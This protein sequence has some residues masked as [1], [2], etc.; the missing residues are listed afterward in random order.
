MK[1]TLLFFVSAFFVASPALAF[2][3]SPQYTGGVQMIPD[4]LTSVAIGDDLLEN[5]GNGS[6]LYLFNATTG[7]WR[8]NYIIIDNTAE[9]LVRI[10]DW[11]TGSDYYVVGVVPY[12][13]L[14]G[15]AYDFYEC[16]A[17]EGFNPSIG[18]QRLYYGSAPEE[19]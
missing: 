19:E 1:K 6:Q 18:Y 17:S 4:G 3:L 15:C 7:A 16:I 8:A 2:E 9:I 10:D 14:L 11:E 13:G 12:A 5:S